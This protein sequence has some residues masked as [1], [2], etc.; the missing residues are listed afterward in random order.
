MCSPFAVRVVGVVGRR[1]RGKGLTETLLS[2]PPLLP[3]HLIIEINPFNPHNTS[4]GD[5]LLL[6]FLY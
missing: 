2:P 3:N 1:D 5:M 6:P 4:M